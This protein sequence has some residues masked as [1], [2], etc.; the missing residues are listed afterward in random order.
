MSLLSI[1]EVIEMVILTIVLII[2][3]KYKSRKLKKQEPIV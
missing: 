3:H 1:F 2:K